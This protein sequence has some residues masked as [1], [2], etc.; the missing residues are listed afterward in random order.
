MIILMNIPFFLGLELKFF[1]LMENL[2]LSS[3][4]LNLE[5]PLGQIK[6]VAKRLEYFNYLPKYMY[7]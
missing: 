5:I 2:K 4:D 1:N 3:L 6:T 7:A